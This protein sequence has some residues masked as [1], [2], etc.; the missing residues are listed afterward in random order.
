MTA[1]EKLAPPAPACRGCGHDTLPVLDLGLMPV[2][3]ELADTATAA[4]ERD[5]FPLVLHLC[6]SCGLLRVGHDLPP[7][8]LFRDYR[9][10]SSYADTMVAHAADLAHRTCDTLG[11]GPDDLVLEIASNDGYLLQHYARRGVLVLGVDPAEDA[12]AVAEKERGVPTVCAFFDRALGRAMA[13][14]GTRPR[15]IHAHN[16]V[17]H[18]PDPLDLLRGIAELLRDD[19]VALVEIPDAG[20][21]LDSAAFD[22]IYHEHYSYYTVTGLVGLLRR[23]GLTVLDIER[24]KVHGGSLLVTAGKGRAP[25]PIRPRVAAELRADAERETSNPRRWARLAATVAARRDELRATLAHLPGPI[26]AYGAS[27][28]G[29]VL[30]NWARLDA[31]E[32]PCVVDRSPHKQGRYVPGVGAEIVPPERIAVEQPAT[33]LLTVWNL[34]EEVRAQQRAFAARG[35]RFVTVVPSV[36]VFP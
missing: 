30:L 13:R 26:W 6:P 12:A 29:C 24:T 2:A 22:T 15:V 8:R 21:L 36:E 35:G 3:N 23:A 28:K 27:A 19:G 11:L 18:V 14:A 1:A 20:N 25:L 17:G 32:I 4:R 10:F 7:A 9:Y 31:R 16:V 5:R 33:L 34:R